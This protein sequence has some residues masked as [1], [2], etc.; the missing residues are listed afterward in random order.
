VNENTVLKKDSSDTSGI[1]LKQAFNNPSTD[2]FQQIARQVGKDTMK[3][4]IDSISYGNKNINGAVDSFWLNNE[5]KISPDEQLGLMSKIYFEQLPFSK[6]SQEMVENLMLQEDN[7]LYK[8]SYT[9]GSGIDEKNNSFEW[10]LGWIE[11]N[12]HVYFFVTFIKSPD[13]T[14]DLKTTGINISKSILKSMGFF[15]G[16]K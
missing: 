9:T 7:T 5:L 16:E 1:T 12:R 6:Y 14:R 4:W 8:L 11:E 2:Y 15:K 13:K 10:V 3:H